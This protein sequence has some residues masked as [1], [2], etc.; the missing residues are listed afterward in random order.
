MIFDWSASSIKHFIALTSPNRTNRLDAISKL[1]CF[2]HLS[3]TYFISL[4]IS[5]GILSGNSFFIRSSVM[6]TLCYRLRSRAL[7]YCLPETRNATA[8]SYLPASMSEL[9]LLLMD[10]GSSALVFSSI[11]EV[12]SL[13]FSACFYV[14]DYG[15]FD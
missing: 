7:S 14:Q 9:T 11:S 4:F 5:G 2:R 8:L 6:G 10:D 15:L 1:P 3:A 12:S 13:F